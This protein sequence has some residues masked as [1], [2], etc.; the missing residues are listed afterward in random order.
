MNILLIGGTGVLSSAVLK[1]SLNKGYTVTIINRG[2]K[3]CEENVELIKADKNDTKTIASFLSGR[4]FDVVCDFLCYTKEELA[5]SFCFYRDYTN[6]YVFISSC[7]VYD[8]SLDKV[9]SEDSEKVLNLWDYSKKKWE[10]EQELIKLAKD[11]NTKY[12][13]VRPAITYGDTRIPY[14]IVPKYGYHWTICSRILAGKP[15]ITWNNGLVRNNMMR[16]EDFAI[17]FV[18]L[19]ANQN[20][21]NECFNLCGDE[22]PTYKEVLTII[23]DY[24][25][26]PVKMIDI[27]VTFY[28]KNVP[29]Q[30]GEIIGGRAYNSINSNAKI[31]EVVPYF[32]QRISLREGVISTLKTYERENYQL[33]I[34]WKYDA[35]SDRVIKKWCRRNKIP[36][37]E[38]HL[39]FIDYL[40]TNDRK[41]FK[42]Y[43]LAY[44][45]DKLLVRLII[46]MVQ[47]IIKRK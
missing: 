17:G 31:K 22:S 21:F 33:G 30:Y 18:G 44:Y 43:L 16:V 27:P 12:T 13:I 36:M 34:D 3:R 23:G 6:Q 14:G 29:S 4:H 20:A 19:F 41:D 46:R 2:N 47:K 1:E 24:L 45:S 25:N 32:S 26:C 8:T 10:A 9:F 39:K 38:Y 5:K 11:S 7:A 15:I 37:E 35:E 40:K 42:Q 28:A